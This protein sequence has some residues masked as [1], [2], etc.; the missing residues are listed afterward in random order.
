MSDSEPITIDHFAKVELRTARVLEVEPHP[1]ADRLW[2][3]SIDAEPS[4]SSG[5]SSLQ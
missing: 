3:L 5:I 1:D 2:L 4:S